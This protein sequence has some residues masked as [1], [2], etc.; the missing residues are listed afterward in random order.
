MMLIEVL[1]LNA[2]SLSLDNV[3]VFRGIRIYPYITF[4]II[5]VDEGRIGPGDQ[6]L[7]PTFYRVREIERWLTEPAKAK[8]AERSDWMAELK[9]RG[10]RVSTQPPSYKS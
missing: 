2:G 4:A 3:K 8:I 6:R 7:T 1:E 10:L 5:A 9:N